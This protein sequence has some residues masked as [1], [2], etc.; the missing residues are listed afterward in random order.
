MHRRVDESADGFRHGKSARIDL[1]FYFPAWLKRPIK[2]GH[3]VYPLNMTLQRL[4]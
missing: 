2:V 4:T 1:A 3:N